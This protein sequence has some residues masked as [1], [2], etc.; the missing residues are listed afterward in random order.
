M[1]ADNTL[2]QALFAGPQS[3]GELTARLNISQPTLSRRIAAMGDAIIRFGNAQLTRYALVRELA[4]QRQFSIYRIN[5][6][7][8]AQLLA[9]ITPVQPEGHIVRLIA[10]NTAT[11]HQN[12]PWWMA[13][14]RPQGFIGRSFVHQW[15]AVLGL[16]NELNL[17][18]DDHALIALS[19][20]GLDCTG[21]LMVG[22]ASLNA[23][24]NQAP[25]ALIATDNRLQRYTELATAALAG[26]LVGSSA[27]GEQPKFNC[28]VEGTNAPYVA[29][30]KFSTPQDN[31][32]T[33]RWR[34]LLV[35]E[36]IALSSLNEAG[37]ACARSELLAT[38][39]Q[40]FLETTRFDRYFNTN[41]RLGRLGVVSL[42]ALDDEFTGLALP[43]PQV[44]QALAQRNIIT[45]VAHQAAAKAHAFGQLIAN[46]DMHRANLSFMYQG[47]LPLAIAPVYDMLPMHYAP[48]SSG[49]IP[50]EVPQINISHAESLPNLRAMLPLAQQFWQFITTDARIS[51]DFKTIAALQIVQLNTLATK[52]N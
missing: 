5:L 3:A 2:T 14:I 21:N 51:Q 43:W 4:G 28:L 8:Q 34:D 44:T 1:L 7:G 24:L 36:H 23:Y 10:A 17:W 41:N 50:S 29:L 22:D 48:R 40:T 32:A 47:E 35:A 37:I 9:S 31:A 13:D 39:T 26:E 46:A 27:G 16:P 6:Q 33:R 25:I 19:Q 52:I 30:V 38:A 12:L 45:Q 42:G 20:H 18:R 49:L 11:Y 15:A